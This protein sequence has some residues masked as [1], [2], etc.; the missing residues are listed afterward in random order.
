MFKIC[1]QFLFKKGEIFLG[2]REK[3][4]LFFSHRILDSGET[5]N[6]TQK[7]GFFLYYTCKD[8]KIWFSY[9]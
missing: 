4:R 7:T 3:S 1:A 6:K 9:L 2:G 8:F 5:K